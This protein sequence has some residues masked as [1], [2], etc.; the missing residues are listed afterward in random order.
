LHRFR[1]EKAATHL[2][3]SELGKGVCKKKPMVTLVLDWNLGG[4][5]ETSPTLAE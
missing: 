4:E 3:I 1:K 2:K 5:T